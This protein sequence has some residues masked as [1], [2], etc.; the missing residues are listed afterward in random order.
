MCL[1]K[2]YEVRDGAEKLLGEYVSELSVAGDM[3][4]LRDIMGVETS[5]CGAIRSIDLV[6]N[7]IIIDAAS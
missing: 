6:K 5:V 1:S 3:V 7:A 2:V 4:T